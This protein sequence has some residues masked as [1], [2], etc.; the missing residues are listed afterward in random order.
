MLVYTITAYDAQGQ[1]FVFPSLPFSLAEPIFQ[2]LNDL[3]LDV[4]FVAV[5]LC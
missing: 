2:L 1:E 5:P 4:T 3:D